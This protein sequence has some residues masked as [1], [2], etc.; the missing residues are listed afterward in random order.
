[1]SDKPDS[2]EICFVPD[3]DHASFV[4]AR[5]G[6]FDTSGEIV[7]TGGRV[8]GTHDGYERFTVGQRKGLRVAMGEPYFVTRIEPDTRRVVIGTR[9]ELAV[10]SLT[11][12]EA[13]WL[14]DPPEEAFRA[15]RQDSLSRTGGGGDRHAPSGKSLPCGLRYPPIR[16][17]PGAGGR[18]LRRRPRPRRGLDRAA[19]GVTMRRTAACAQPRPWRIIPFFNTSRSYNCW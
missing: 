18:L 19:L 10:G 7:T 2:Q 9:E 4:K 16:R 8:V 11:A 15:K 14:V 17:R 6:D 1:M 3:Q 12:G 5:T 13:N